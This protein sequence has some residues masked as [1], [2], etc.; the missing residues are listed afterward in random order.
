MRFAMTQVSGRR[1]DELGNL[2]AVLK[3]GAVNLDAGA[4]L[5]VQGL[6]HGLDHTRLTRASGAKKQEI[7]YRVVGRVQ[8]GQKHLIDF[9]DFLNGL[10]LPYD[11]AR[12]SIFKVH[13]IAAATKRIECGI[14]AGLHDCC[15][16]RKLRGP[17]LAVRD[18][19]LASSV[20]TR[21]PSIV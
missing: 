7:A 18:E 19:T 17:M 8:P 16:S 13:G 20:V 14:K 1:A 12:Q 2:V 21:P 9:G 11:F 3:F 15:P 10:I 4:R 5:A 6:G